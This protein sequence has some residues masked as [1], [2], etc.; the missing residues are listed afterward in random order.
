MENLVEQ[1]MLSPEGHV[2]KNSSMCQARDQG[3]F[4]YEND[5][6]RDHQWRWSHA[7]S[8][9]RKDN[10]I[11]PIFEWVK[12]RVPK[13][14]WSEAAI[15]SATLQSLVF[16]NGIVCRKWY[17]FKQKRCTFTVVLRTKVKD[18]LRS[19]CDWISGGHLGV[20]RTL[21][22]IWQYF[23]WINCHDAEGWCRNV[24]IVQQ[25]KGHIHRADKFSKLCSV[26]VSWER[27][28]LVGCHRTISSD[29]IWKTNTFWW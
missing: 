10:D 15:V 23:H 16:Y 5:K 4:S 27:I 19:L 26:G 28:T 17:I 2:L 1:H 29:W 25:L 9:A 24:Q 22:K 18:V 6:N 13:P 7:A 12:D 8:T 14:K 21:M 3:H 11:K 20:K